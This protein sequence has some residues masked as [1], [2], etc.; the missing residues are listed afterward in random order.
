MEEKCTKAPIFTLETVFKDSAEIPI[1]IE[2]NMPDYCPEISRILKCKAAVRIS[3]A[4]AEGRKI[5][6]DGTATV[7]VTYA[8]SENLVNSYEYQYPFSKSFDT[9]VD[10]SDSFIKSRAK[11]EY[12][13]CRAV[14]G[15]KLDI[16]GAAG[17]YV[18]ALMKKSRDIICDIESEGIEVLRSTA[19]T[20]MPT[21]YAEKYLIIE[22]EI[23]VGPSQPDVRCLISYDAT[24]HADEC[25]LL[26][27]KAVVRGELAVSILY[28]GDD[29]EL[30][31]LESKIPFSQLVEAEGV[32][33]DC[34][35]KVAAYVA[36]LEIKPKFNASQV[37]RGFS[38]DGKIRLSLEAYCLSEV[39][40]ITDAYS[41]KYEAEISGDEVTFDRLVCNV[42]DTFNFKK[43]LDFPIDSVSRI[44]D[45]KCEPKPESCTFED[46]CF[47]LS[48]SVNCS[49]L[50]VDESGAPAYYEKQTDFEYRYK[51]PES[52]EDLNAQ[53]EISVIS[54]GYTITGGNRVEVRAEMAVTAAVYESKRVSLVSD[55]TVN[56]SRLIGKSGRG[57]LTVY[58]AE[59]GES[60]WDVARKY[61]ADIDEVRQI[62]GL[63][64]DE[65]ISGQMILV[66]MK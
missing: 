64:D 4:G 16:H 50:A 43:E 22:D 6:V 59:S 17:V 36:Y 10:V 37:S 21:G 49:M 53:P 62:N 25:K 66:P 58:F 7:T 48:G 12:V 46:D 19:P 24:A 5:S 31:P 30:Q 20:V 51:L 29:G 42:K 38:L 27:G 32:S 2:I 8:D 39:A 41:R 44:C 26:A 28:R 15:R 54:C 65:L 40:F 33:E 35:C 57:A 11:C 45:M 63:G 13:N 1:D 52:G 47:M 55:V 18:T 3:A 56:E 60:V 61:L 34:E 23:E 9:G 14:S